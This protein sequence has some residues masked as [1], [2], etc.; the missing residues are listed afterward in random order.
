[1]T[2]DPHFSFCSKFLNIYLPHGFLINSYASF[3]LTF[4][5]LFQYTSTQRGG[6]EMPLL[7]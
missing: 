7:K 1:M 5:S 2:K 3:P 4:I 6:G